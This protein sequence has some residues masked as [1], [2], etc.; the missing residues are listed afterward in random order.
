VYSGFFVNY[1]ILIHYTNK[2]GKSNR[3]CLLWMIAFHF[4]VTV[5]DRS[6]LKLFLYFRV[7]HVKSKHHLMLFI[8]NDVLIRMTFIIELQRE[9]YSFLFS[10]FLC[11]LHNFYN[12]LISLFKLH[13]C[14]SK[15]LKYLFSSTCWNIQQLFLLKISWNN[16]KLSIRLFSPLRLTIIIYITVFMT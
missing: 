9:K 16:S 11:E 4:F 13:F 14:S 2:Y 15:T 12:P 1:Y 10:S 6:L 7:L 5:Y 8:I 3:N